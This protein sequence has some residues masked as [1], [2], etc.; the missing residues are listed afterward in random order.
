MDIK[1]IKL[2]N[3]FILKDFKVDFTFLNIVNKNNMIKR[4][5]KRKSLNRYDKFKNNFY[6]KVQRGYLQISKKN[7]LKYQVINSNLDIEYNKKEI[8]KSIDRLL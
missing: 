3:D 6:Q 2:I 7:K 8:I 5:K 4:L 1:F